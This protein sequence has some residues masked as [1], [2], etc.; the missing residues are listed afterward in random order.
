[1]QDGLLVVKRALRRSGSAVDLSKVLVSDLVLSVEMVQHLV[2]LLFVRHDQVYIF[3]SLKSL[4]V[5]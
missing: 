5:V 4:E 1:M 2:K 3:Q